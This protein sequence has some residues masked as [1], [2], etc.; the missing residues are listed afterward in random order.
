[1]RNDRAKHSEYE[2]GS[3]NV[4]ADLGLP[5]PIERQTKARLMSSINAEIKRLHLTQTAAA[6]RVGLSQPDVSKIACGQGAAFSVER[7]IGVLTRLGVDV[8]ITLHHGAGE[9][10]VREL[11]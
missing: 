1:M 8:E 2:L 5:N 3:T 10:T 9:V 6:Q 7:L 4:F 11:V